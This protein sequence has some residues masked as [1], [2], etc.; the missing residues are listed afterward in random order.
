MATTIV[1]KDLLEAF[2]NE[3][4]KDTNFFNG[5]LLTASD[6]VTLQ[7]ASRKRDR[8]LGLAA[9]AGVVT[10]LEVRLVADG[11]DGAPPVLAV[12][13]GLAINRLGQAVALAQD[14]EVRLAKPATV[15]QPIA[16]LFNCCPPP[17]QNGEPLP[18]KGAYL[19]VAR[20]ASDYKGLAPRRGFGQDIKVEGC[21]RDLL[22]EGVQFRT[23]EMNLA[24]F[25]RLSA[26]TQQQI[27]ELMTRTGDA[28]LSKLRNWLAHICLGTEELG[29]FV[30]DPWPRQADPFFQAALGSSYHLYGAAD[31]LRTLGDLDDCDI[32]LAMLFWKSLGVSFVDMW[33]VRRRLV[34][35]FSS[36]S[37]PQ[38]ASERRL[39]EAVAAFQ[40]FQDQINALLLRL[41]PAALVAAHSTDYFRYLPAAS[42]LPLQRNGFR[43]FDP[44]AFFDQPHRDVEFIDGLTMRAILQ[45][46]YTYEPMD[47][48]AD[49]LVWLYQPWQNAKAI[50]DGANIQPYLLFTTGHMPHKALARLDVARWNY[51][52]YA[53]A[54]PAI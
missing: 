24:D 33:A 4:S 5:R 54:Y 48:A 7:D 50:D 14:A 47:L 9:G 22:L 46:A 39:A 8:Q 42:I 53:D 28:D 10:G 6:L 18:G 32:P 20:P 45:D 30:E 43:G 41:N 38:P 16:G 29:Q 44:V 26:T 21:G 12:S 34:T 35:S 3:E 19:L 17:Q 2:L 13:K 31:T 11:S 23:V 25:T 1:R 49:E 51:S 52:H 27:T 15:A 37:W 40:Q 36:V